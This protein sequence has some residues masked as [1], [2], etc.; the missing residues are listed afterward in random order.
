MCLNLITPDY[1]IAKDNITVYKVLREDKGEYYTPYQNIKINLDEGQQAEITTISDEIVTTGIHSYLNKY[2]AM[3]LLA[4]GHKLFECYIPKGTKYYIGTNSDIVC[5]DL[6]YVKEVKNAQKI[7]AFSTK[8]IRKDIV[9]E[10]LKSTFILMG[11]PKDLEIGKE[12]HK[13]Y[14]CPEYL[15][16]YENGGII[17]MTGFYVNR[18]TPFFRSMCETYVVEIPVDSKVL[19]NKSNEIIFT[20]T[21]KVIEKCV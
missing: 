5:E 7:R 16:N 3:I 15:Y 9:Y 18:D 11:D 1:C 13:Y 10:D 6:R 20:D 19:I 17:L 14:P 2:Y 12:Y 4:K 21:I 8:H